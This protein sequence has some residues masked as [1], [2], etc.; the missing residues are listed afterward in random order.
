ML[1]DLLSV[2]AGGD[3]VTA[4]VDRADVPDCAGLD[5]AL[6]YLDRPQYLLAVE[7]ADEVSSSH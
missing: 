4:G 7:I 5:V 6:T 1:H 3:S 2:A